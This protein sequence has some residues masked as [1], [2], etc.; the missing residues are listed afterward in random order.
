MPQQDAQVMSYEHWVRTPPCL[1][2]L[3][4]SLSHKNL[5]DPLIE[6]GV[7]MLWSA[8]ATFNLNQVCWLLQDPLI[9][10]IRCG[11]DLLFAEEGC[12]KTHSLMGSCPLCIRFIKAD[13]FK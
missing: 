8:D 9:N 3:M 5:P 11:K 7:V 10:A 12:A 2:A 4:L 13:W 6:S 1:L